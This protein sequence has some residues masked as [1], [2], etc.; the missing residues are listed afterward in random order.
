M[1]YDHFTMLPEMAFQPIGGR[2]TLEGGGGGK[3][4]PPPPPPPPAPPPQAAKAPDADIV[5]SK[6]KKA[7]SGGME[8]GPGTTFLTGPSGVN[9]D[10]LTLGRNTLLGG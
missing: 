7:M 10:D 5:R 2:M 6:N 1:R 3:T 4:K 8:A 9:P